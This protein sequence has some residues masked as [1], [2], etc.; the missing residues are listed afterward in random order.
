MITLLALS[1]KISVVLGVA[2]VCAAVFRRSAAALR[3]LVWTAALLCCLALPVLSVVLPRWGSTDFVRP[4]AAATTSSGQHTGTVIVVTPSAP[5]FPWIEWGWAAGAVIVLA[6][7]GCGL[8]LLFWTGSRAR[9]A[10]GLPLLRQATVQAAALGV[11]RPLRVLISRS[12]TQMPMTWALVRPKIL[13]PSSASDWPE[14][15]LKRVLAHELAHV[16]RHDW[17]WRMCGELACALYWFHPLV[18]FAASSLQEESERACDDLVLRS[19]VPAADYADQLLILARTFDRASGA[20]SAGLAMARRSNFERRLIAM[21]NPTFHRSSL[22]ARARTMV[23]I[24]AL[25]VLGPLAGLRAPGQGLT[26]TLSGTVYDPSRAAVPRAVVTAS[27][28]AAKPATK[29][30]VNTDGAGR[31]VFNNLPQGVYE[32]QVK[33]PGFA[34]ATVAGVAIES[35]R[36]TSKNFTID[37]GRITEVV[38]VSAPGVAQAKSRTE[39]LGRIAVGG[40]VQPAKLEYKVNPVYPPSAQAAGI[41]GIVELAAVV[42]TDGR[43]LSL[44]VLSSSADPELVTAAKDAVSQWRYSP[45]RLNGMPVEVVTQIS[46]QFSLNQ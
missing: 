9:S 25:C 19:G 29:D 1:I 21:L 36:E 2:G 27:N 40:N 26:G 28:T 6:R 38:R 22:S 23:V 13:L 39:S 4:P 37:L 20:W 32:L 43:V 24:A 18:W 11:S 3:H 15:R 44:K 46:V 12:A 41:T 14:Q 30:T 5:A 16:S 35:G 17:I 45:T 34:P 7:L 33:A 42:G 31:F 8:A 10:H